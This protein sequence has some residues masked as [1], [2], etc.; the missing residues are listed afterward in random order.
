MRKLA[1]FLIVVSLALV[2][3]PTAFGDA[4]TTSL[5]IDFSGSG[6]GKLT[7][8]HPTTYVID[9][10]L[11]IPHL[12]PSTLHTD[13]V[14]ATSGCSPP[15]ST[16][17]E[18]IVDANGNALTNSGTT[19]GT[20]VGA[21]TT[22]TG[23]GTFTGGT[24]RFKGTGG[25]LTTTATL[26]LNRATL[27]FT[28][29]FTST[30]TITV[31]DS[32]YPQLL[33]NGRNRVNPAELTLWTGNVARLKRSWKFVKAPYETYASPVVDSGMVFEGLYNCCPAPSKIVALNATTGAVVWTSPIPASVVVTSAVSSGVVFV[34]DYVG[35][36]HALNEKT[37]AQLWT[38]RAGQQFFDSEH[39]TVVGTTVLTVTT[40]PPAGSVGST[41][42]AWPAAGCGAATC[43]PLWTASLGA[44]AWGAASDGQT[45]FVADQGGTLYAYNLTGCKASSCS[46]LW[47]AS[48]PSTSSY[49]SIAISAGTVY[50]G[51]QGGS[52]VA[53]FNANGCA[54]ATCQ[55]LA[56]YNAADT[57]PSGLAVA[58]NLV[59]VGDNASLQAFK[60][61]C[62]PGSTCQ[63]VWTDTGAPNAKIIEANNIV[64][65]VSGSTVFADDARTGA[66]LWADTNSVSGEPAAGP[67]IANGKLYVGDTHGNSIVA[68]TLAAP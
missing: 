38:G 31:N 67:T 52:A 34:G 61:S 45:V 18:T 24:G 54:A 23:H 65:G 43:S 51:A 42:A 4:Q 12:G 57:Q 27:T 20:T 28:I 2:G 50:V 35:T 29:T 15:T 25:T 22:I 26:V 13:G 46:P 8:G 41:L 6:S 49:G 21:T 19:T 30:G 16:Y 40:V 44:T 3:T 17:T 9:A 53:S 11:V 63:P 14:C 58:D 36:L 48:Y 39:I 56:L 60:T 47:T 10:T 33:L 66:R 59:L 37:G 1:S 64:Y 68:Y 5:P 7:L 32:S 62:P 55:P